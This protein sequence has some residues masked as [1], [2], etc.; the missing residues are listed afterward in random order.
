MA[1]KAGGKEL[2]KYSNQQL[3]RSKTEKAKKWL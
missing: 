1:Y 3:R 2:R